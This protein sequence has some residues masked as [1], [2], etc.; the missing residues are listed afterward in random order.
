MFVDAACMQYVED[1]KIFGLKN[2]WIADW[3][4]LK[5]WNFGL[6]IGLDGIKKLSNCGL[7]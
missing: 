3:F 7:D 2:V 1:L 4:E 6:G 5:I